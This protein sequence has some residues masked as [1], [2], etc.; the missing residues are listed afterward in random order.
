[1]RCPAVSLALESRVPRGTFLFIVMWL[2]IILAH[3]R[4]RKHVEYCVSFRLGTY[5]GSVFW[6]NTI[7]LSPNNIIL[8]SVCLP[9][10]QFYLTICLSYYMSICLFVEF[11]IYLSGAC[12]SACLTFA[13]LSASLL[14]VYQ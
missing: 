5:A 11:S 10:C 14:I 7:L 2:F 6:S 9:K 3:S 8:L 1:M 13:R 12:L 4:D